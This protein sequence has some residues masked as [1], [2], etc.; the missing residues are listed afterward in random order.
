MRAHTTPV[1]A[2]LDE[3]A[4]SHRIGRTPIAS[5]WLCRGIGS[6]RFL[7]SIGR[8]GEWWNSTNA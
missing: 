3:L 4:S 6:L 2:Y 7:Q 8:G 5:H 1:C